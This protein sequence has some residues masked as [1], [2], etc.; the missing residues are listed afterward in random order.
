MASTSKFCFRIVTMKVQE[1]KG[2]E[3]EWAHQVL[4]YADDV[5]LLCKNTNTVKP[6]IF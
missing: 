6:E 4:V 1:T 3:I 2:D 5:N